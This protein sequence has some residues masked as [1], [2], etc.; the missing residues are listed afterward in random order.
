MTGYKQQ[1]L[2]LDYL[3]FPQECAYY[4]HYPDYFVLL[5]IHKEKHHGYI[6][7]MTGYKQQ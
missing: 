5:P 7:L 4:K 3:P 2:T 6:L 1:S